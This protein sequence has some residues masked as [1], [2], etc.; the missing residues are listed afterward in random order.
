M[1]HFTCFGSAGLPKGVIDRWP[2]CWVI[3]GGHYT[4]KSV[5]CYTEMLWRASDEYHVHDMK[6]VKIWG[7]VSEE[8][9]ARLCTQKYQLSIGRIEPIPRGIAAFYLA[10]I[11]SEPSH[12]SV[13]ESAA[14]HIRGFFFRTY[15]LVIRR[16]P[17]Y[18]RVFLDI[19]TN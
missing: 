4:V 3:L 8:V 19:Y 13:S 16:N 2:T 15:V 18:S 11:C 17:D 10:C 5:P 1:F 9:Y 6:L 14:S 7:D 12:I